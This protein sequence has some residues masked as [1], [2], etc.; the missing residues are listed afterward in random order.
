MTAHPAMVRATYD[1]GTR[2]ERLF[3]LSRRP[4][5]GVTQ[6]DLT[7]KSSTPDSTQSAIARAIRARG[8]K[9]APAE[10]GE[11]EIGQPLFPGSVQSET[12]SLWLGREAPPVGGVEAGPVREV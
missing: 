9:P 3:L 2:L 6:N 12:N 10:D 5:R 7:K 1:A 4:L 8:G 11:P